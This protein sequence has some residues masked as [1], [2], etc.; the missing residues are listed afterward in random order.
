M[1]EFEL[2][3]KLQRTRDQSTTGEVGLKKVDAVN[4]L[5]FL[6]A[7]SIMNLFQKEWRLDCLYSE[8]LQ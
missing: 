5:E 8:Q 4:F 1:Q 2:G 6:K 7:K 3:P